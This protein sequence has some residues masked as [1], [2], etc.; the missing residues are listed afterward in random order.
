MQLPM[1]KDLLLDE[2]RSARTIISRWLDDFEKNGVPG[3]DGQLS[4]D[5]LELFLMKICGELTVCANKCSSLASV[6]SQTG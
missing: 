4:E 1:T 5:Q 3:E 2:L 6:L